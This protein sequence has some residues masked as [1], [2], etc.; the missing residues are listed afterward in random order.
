M[1]NEGNVSSK[2]LNHHGL[3]ASV[4][5]DLGL[6]ELINQRIKD[7]D[8]RRIVSP[9]LAV[10]A[11]IINGLGFLNKRLYMVA[12]FF[13]DKPTERLIGEGIQAEHLNDDILGKTL[14]QIY[15]F[16]QT[17]LF[18]E[19][20]YEIATNHHCLNR[21]RRIDT[22]SFKV[23]GEYEPEKGVSSEAK[24]LSDIQE[25][26][27]IVHGFSKDGR[28]D[29]KQF[30]LSLVMSGQGDLPIW[31]ESQNGNSSDKV[32]FHDTIANVREF[33][34]NLDLEPSIWVAD[35]ALYTK[36]RLLRQE[37]DFN[38]IC[39]VPE[40]LKESKALVSKEIKEEDWQIDKEDNSYQFFQ[41]EI[42]IEGIKQRWIL[43]RSKQARSK[44]EETFKKNIEKELEACQQELKKVSKKVFD[45]QN[46][47]K[48]H[49][50]A[51]VKKKKKFEI[52]F[53]IEEIERFAKKGRPSKGSKP[54]SVG[55]RL[56]SEVKIKEEFYNQALLTKG[57]FILATNEMNALKLSPS[58]IL[59]EYK[60]QQ[61]PERGF[62]FLKDPYFIAGEV[63]L[64]K[65]ER[66]EALLFVMVLC[67]LV[68]NF[69]QNRLRQNLFDKDDTL[70]NQLGK[71]TN[72]PTFRW[73]ME[74]MSGIGVV[75]IQ[76]QDIW[77]IIVTNLDDIKRKIIFYFGKYAQKIYGMG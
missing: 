63:Y 6:V 38:W 43:V 13:K 4:V 71:Q 56:I 48:N 34:K 52:M 7:E 17:K 15:E 10:K 28:P 73:V 36:E 53:R 75:Y 35:A 22:T 32:S 31:M 66:I 44:E 67:L 50:E 26:L 37:N 11:M 20:A 55:Y 39:R 62:R 59:K 70:P 24:P 74:M 41:S 3:V 76:L 29:L 14:D 77:Q 45:C 54:L 51:I 2:E 21:Y 27:Q 30:M 18:A 64:K 60:N 46:D 8:K 57:R 47:A 23:E 69:A 72:Q 25:K 49:I 65:P 58:E 19:I 12:K 33:E 40:S 68:Y 61:S 5:E 16:G 42:E 1:L 9:G